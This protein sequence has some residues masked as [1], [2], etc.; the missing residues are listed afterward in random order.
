MDWRLLFLNSILLGF[1]LA[2]DAFSVSVAD[3]MANPNMKSGKKIS[4]ALTFAVFQTLMPLVGWF[5]VR[6]IADKF[7]LFQ[8]A[9]PYIALILLAYI[10]I[11]MIIESRKD[12]EEENEGVAALTFA[13]LIIQGVATSI[14]ALSVG[15]AIADYSSLEALVSTLI[16]GITTFIICI[17]G[18]ELGKKVGKAFSDKATLFGGCILIIIGL[19]IF[20]KGVFF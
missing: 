19:E 9:I 14:D 8:K 11:K 17:F 18:L 13:T 5:C 10:G 7:S 12:G 16:I 4:I 3:A 1:G 20:I 15:F 2:L 6:T